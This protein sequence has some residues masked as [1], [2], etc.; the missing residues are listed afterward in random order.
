MPRPIERDTNIY[1]SNGYDENGKRKDTLVSA[2]ME[3]G[4]EIAR[5]RNPNIKRLGSRN[6]ESPTLRLAASLL[7]QAADHLDCNEYNEY[8][9]T[10]Q[11]ARSTLST[12]TDIIYKVSKE[13]KVKE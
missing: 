12:I 5:R 10:L 8:F 4:E 7:N 3:H 6:I 13:M 11:H 2:F 9:E 1:N